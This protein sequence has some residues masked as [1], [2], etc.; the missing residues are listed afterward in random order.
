MFTFDFVKPHFDSNILRVTD[1]LINVS[2]ERTMDN[3]KRTISI[4]TN[5]V[6]Y[7]I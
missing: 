2:V 1:K 5:N 3:I 7:K 6:T 4:S